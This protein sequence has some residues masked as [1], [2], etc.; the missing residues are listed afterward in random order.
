LTNQLTALELGTNSYAE[1][2]MGGACS[3]CTGEMR[4]AYKIFVV[5]PEVNRPRG[6]SRRIREVNV[7]MILEE[8][9]C[10]GA[11]WIRLP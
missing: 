4:N 9:G 8:S 6:R 2:E 10:D 7:K 5:K 3:V 1:G 11:D